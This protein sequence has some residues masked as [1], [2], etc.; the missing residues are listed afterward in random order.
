MSKDKYAH[1]S[2]CEIII[3]H[4]ESAETNYPVN[5]KSM[6]RSEDGELLFSMPKTT[7]DSTMWYILSVGNEFF[8]TGQKSG[9][10]KCK[11]NI[12]KALGLQETCIIW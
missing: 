4:E 6:I 3:N 8:S 5:K 2:D 10:I 12:Q 11:L 9:D 7:P 1:K